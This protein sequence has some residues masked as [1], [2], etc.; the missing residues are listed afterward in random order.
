MESGHPLSQDIQRQ[1]YIDQSRI[2][3]IVTSLK[4]D[5]NLLRGIVE[6]ANTSAGYDMRGLIRQGCQASF[7]M[8]ALGN[9]IKEE[10]SYKRVYGPLMIIS[11][12]WVLIDG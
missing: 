11:Y 12:D 9:V 6:T 8:R 5:G 4:W 2:S 7:S 10:A 3:H 1:A